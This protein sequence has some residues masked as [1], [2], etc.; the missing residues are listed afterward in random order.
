[1]NFGQAVKKKIAN[2]FFSGST[3]S[4]TSAKPAL[5]LVTDSCPKFTPNHPIY[6]R[7]TG[8]LL[9]TLKIEISSPSSTLFHGKNY[10][11]P[12]YTKTSSLSLI[13]TTHT[14]N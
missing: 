8:L 14:T 13:K 1:M 4:A 10:P 9:K 3:R 6:H 11:L 2:F 12:L 5:S 7:N